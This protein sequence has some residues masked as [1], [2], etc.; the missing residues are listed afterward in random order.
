R[1]PA[2]HRG[3][4][5]HGGTPPRGPDLRRIR[6]RPA[7]AAPHGRLR[8]R[9]GGPAGD[10]AQPADGAGGHRGARL[11]RA[12]G[13][14]E[15]GDGLES[16][17]GPHRA[18]P[19]RLGEVGAGPPRLLPAGLRSGPGDRVRRRDP[20]RRFHREHGTAAGGSAG[21]RAEGTSTTH[22]SG[23]IMTSQQLKEV[24]RVSGGEEEHGHLE[25]FRTDPIGLMQRVRD[26]CGDVGY[27]QLVDKPVIL[28]TGAEANEFFF[29]A[30]DEDLDQA[31]AY[32]FMT[33]IFGKGVVFDA[34]PERRKEMLHNSALR[35]EHM[36]SHATTIEG[37][38]RKMIAD[39]GDEGEIDLLDFF[40][41]LTIYT[42][43][44]CLIGLKFRNQLDKR[45]AEYYHLLERGT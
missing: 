23:D 6:C 10:G 13:A 43:T 4:A 45:F 25:E 36:K 34:S 31:A 11:D 14:D 17:P 39:W 38:V 26:E 27:F 41:E 20:P 19:Q 37:E 16:A 21:R 40:A 2:G 22:V 8:R 15:D 32:P 5:G 44:A 3:A 9:Q 7:P 1:E 29:R 35:G 30:A 12:P 28:L 18:G 42:S 33:P 24:P